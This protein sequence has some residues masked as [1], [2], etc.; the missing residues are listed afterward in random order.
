MCEHGSL[1]KENPTS[2]RGTE[3]Y[4]TSWGYR[5]NESLDPGKTGYGKEKRRNSI[6]GINDNQREWL[7]GETE[8]NFSIVLFGI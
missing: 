1:Q 3:V 5:E 6:E 7:D 4:T 8:I 2:Q